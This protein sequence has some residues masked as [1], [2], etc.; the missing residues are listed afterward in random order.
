MNFQHRLKERRK[1]H[2]KIM[3]PELNHDFPSVLAAVKAAEAGPSMSDIDA[4]PILDEWW[5]AFDPHRTPF[6]VGRVNDHPVLGSKSIRTSRLL[7]L[8]EHAGW[9][10]TFNRWYR[11][12]AP[13]SAPPIPMPGLNPINSVENLAALLAEYIKRVRELEAA[14]LRNT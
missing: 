3:P 12:G 14:P 1:M 7:A 11:L 13:A 8:N 5:P 10:R 2:R 6:L 4:V 9:A